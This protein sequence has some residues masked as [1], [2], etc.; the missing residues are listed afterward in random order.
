MIVAGVDIGSTATK[1]VLASMDSSVLAHAMVPTR[2]DVREASQAGLD[3][4][5]E[6]AGVHQTD[7]RSTV[8]TGYGRYRSVLGD[9]VI[10]EITCHALGASLLFPGARTVLD[11]GGQDTKA[12]SIGRR[13]EVLDY[14]MNDRCA[15]GT[16]AFL[17]AAADA[18]GLSLDD[19]GS[20]AVQA[21]DSW[22]I[23]SVCT[24]FAEQ[25]LLSSVARGAAVD[26][27][28]R[29]M[30]DAVARR[31]VGLMRR[32]ALRPPFAFT[33]G[34]ASNSGVADALERSLGAAVARSHA[35][36]FAGALGAAV[37]AARR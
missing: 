12:I 27:L 17:E 36:V 3:A 1:V 16:G 6:A 5:L 13:G 21:D 29:G 33:G 30:C 26:V 28:A 20:A 22:K 9:Q 37:L 35:S 34:V 11:I 10:G 31:A 8:T 14:C 25:E 15:A 4:A 2:M 24:V 32:V 18:L 7:V 19:V 23:S